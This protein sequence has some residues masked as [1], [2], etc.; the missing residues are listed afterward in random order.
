MV[1]RK[2]LPS[3]TLLR[4]LTDQIVL[5]TV[6]GQAPITRAEIAQCTGISKTT[7]SE[8]VRRLEDAGL[9]LTAGT[10]T[11]RQGRVGTY[12]QVAADA[13]FAVAVDLN[14]TEIRVRAADLF[15]VPFLD[16]W[17]APTDPP[18][19][20]RG[21]VTRAIDRGMAE[22]RRLLAVGVS[23]ANP[24]DPATE[25]VV[26]LPDTPYPQGL[27]RPQEVLDGLFEA[28][29]LVDNDVNLAA[30][31]ERWHGAGR[32]VHSF[33]YVHIGAGMGMGLVIGDQLVRGSHGVA[34]EIGY[35]PLDSGLRQGFTLA[36]LGSPNTAARGAVI[37]RAIASVCALVDPELVLLGGPLG[38]DPDLLDP[39]RATV[40]ELAPVP[41]KI[42]FGALGESA[43]VRGALEQALQRGRA[44]LWAKA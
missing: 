5:D 12:Y 15:G 20:L 17:H 24:V 33:A 39:V 34:G 2:A 31:A 11:G 7:V 10:Q 32:D 38:L 21:L 42:E 29:L 36:V 9:L 16:E 44:D 1:N 28:P 22:H 41:P 40:A 14:S 26:E 13:G 18:C 6:F 23:V 4:E 25:S 19:Q 30:I 3:M 35:L 27:F 8:A 37:G 43:A